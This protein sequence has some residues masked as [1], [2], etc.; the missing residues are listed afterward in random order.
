MLIPAGLPFSEAQRVPVDTTN[1]EDN[2]YKFDAGFYNKIKS[3]QSGAGGHSNESLYHGVILATTNK[4]ALI[5]NI[6]TNYNAQ[7]IF[8]PKNLEFVITAEILID[9]IPSLVLNENVVKIGDGFKPLHS[10]SI[11]Y[12]QNNNTHQSIADAKIFHSITSE[13][14][15]SGDG[16]LVGI[17]DINIPPAHNDL[18][19]SKITE[20]VTCSDSSCE[21]RSPITVDT[22]FN[23]AASIIA[24]TGN[25]NSNM[26]GIA[27]DSEIIFIATRQSD[28]QIQAFD[29]LL[30]KNVDV[31]TII[32]GDYMPCS[33]YPMLALVVDEVVDRGTPVIVGMGNDG[34]LVTASCAYNAISVGNV[35]NQRNIAD[36]STR[37]GESVNYILKPEISALGTNIAGASFGN[38]YVVGTGTSFSTPII[39]AITA[40]MLEKNSNLTPQEI[41]VA[42]MLGADA[43]FSSGTAKNFEDQNQSLSDTINKFGSGIVNATKSLDAVDPQNNQIKVGEFGSNTGNNHSFRINAD[44]GDTVKLFLN[45]PVKPRT[46]D[47]GHVIGPV[48]S[49]RLPFSAFPISAQIANFD[50]EVRKPDGTRITSDANTLTTEFIVFQAPQSGYY[51]VNVETTNTL[52]TDSSPT[53][54]YALGSTHEIQTPPYPA[55]PIDNPPVLKE[56]YN[57]HL[58][59]N[60]QITFDVTA[61]DEDDD[62][63]TLTVTNTLPRFATFTDNGNGVGTFVINSDSVDDDY[64]VNVRASSMDLSDEDDFYIIVSEPDDDDPPRYVKPTPPPAINEEA[65]G[66]LTFVRL[67]APEFED[68]VDSELDIQHDAGRSKILC[69]TSQCVLDCN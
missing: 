23:Q 24:G 47:N 60:S 40:L 58:N 21:A 65:S 18:P 67:V 13:I 29:Y 41:D 50:L 52:R 14:T 54:P 61:T 26:K 30:E 44:E 9:Q 45:F 10:I 49:A 39:T 5:D 38:N 32:S 4:T 2:L 56:I 7:N 27:Y 3:L 62:P 42:L 59:T 64:Y 37:G 57:V 55:E 31:V 69:R 63:I 15:Q 48:S 17:M 53:I 22:H 6:T 51:Y 11:P 8:N 66:V 36:S 1:I 28:S 34:L 20:I 68:N 35:D 33:D 25:S 46:E 43:K 19:T 12:N 16:I